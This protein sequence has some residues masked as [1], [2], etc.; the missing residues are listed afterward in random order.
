MD[1]LTTVFV[2]SFQLHPELVNGL[3]KAVVF[4]DSGVILHVIRSHGFFVVVF[5]II[6]YYVDSITIAE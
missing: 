1:G 5:S 2:S 6:A 3:P 4:G